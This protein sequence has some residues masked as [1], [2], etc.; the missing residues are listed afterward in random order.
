[1]VE[2]FGNTA[3][4]HVL[5]AP[6][7]QPEPTFKTG[8]QQM[9]SIIYY[10]IMLY[11]AT[12]LVPDTK[13][14]CQMVRVVNKCTSRTIRIVRSQLQCSFLRNVIFVVYMRT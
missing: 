14:C 11:V 6:N 1:M 10:L 5:I 9:G 4:F 2:M 3:R 7:V 13:Y 12:L 8:K